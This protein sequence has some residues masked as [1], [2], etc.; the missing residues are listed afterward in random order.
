MFDAA[1]IVVLLYGYIPKQ[2]DW[3]VVRLFMKH[4]RVRTQ[5]P[6]ERAWNPMN[7]QRF[8]GWFTRLLNALP[9]RRA[10]RP[11]RERQRARVTSPRSTRRFAVPDSNQIRRQQADTNPLCSTLHEDMPPATPESATKPLLPAPLPP[12]WTPAFPALPPALSSVPASASASHE[13]AEAPVVQVDPERRLAFA[14]YLVKRGVFNEGFASER[15]PAQ[16]RR[17]QQD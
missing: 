10:R 1:G 15:L 6:R 7:M 13:A 11:A 16:Y 2:S 4:L 5:V 3:R 9:W 14:R 17:T 12:E 8:L